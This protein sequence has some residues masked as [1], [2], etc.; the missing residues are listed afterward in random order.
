MRNFLPYHMLK[1]NILLYKNKIA[2]YD[3]GLDREF[4]F[5]ELFIETEKLCTGLLNLGLKRGD[6][7]A[8]ISK[9]YI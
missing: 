7:I 4:T 3:S 1:R 6:R 2:I 8:V 5:Y 9:K